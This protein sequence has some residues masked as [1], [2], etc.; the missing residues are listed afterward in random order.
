MPFI[1]SYLCSTQEY[2]IRFAV[3][4][5]LDFFINETYIEQ[6]LDLL[7]QVHHEGYYV[8]MAV[9]WAASMCYAAFPDET[10]P[11]LQAARLDEFT[12]RRTIR[13]ICESHQVNAEQK[14]HLR[15]LERRRHG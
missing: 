2:E 12:Y 13:K 1:Q 9:A 3:V 14:S 6:V 10:L 5:L 11:W 8:K 7:L 4:C 15:A